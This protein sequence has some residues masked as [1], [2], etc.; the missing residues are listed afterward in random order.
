MT[1]EVGV[2]VRIRVLLQFQHRRKTDINICV[3]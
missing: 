2:S 3:S 1:E